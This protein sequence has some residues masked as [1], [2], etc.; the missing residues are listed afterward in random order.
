MYSAGTAWEGHPVP[1][2]AKKVGLILVF[3]GDLKKH[4]ICL[5]GC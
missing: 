5:A 4:M 2:K 1:D 3:D